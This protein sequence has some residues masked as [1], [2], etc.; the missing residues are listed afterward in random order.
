MNKKFLNNLKFAFIAQSVSILF[1]LIMYLI[2]PKIIGVINYSYWQLFLFYTNY[3]GFFHLGLVDGI[4][5][6]LGGREYKELNYKRIGSQFKIMFFFHMLIAIVCAIAFCC[7]DLEEERVFVILCTILYIVIY[8]IEN[9]LGFVLQ[10]VN[11][12]KKYSIAVIIEKIVCLIGT[13]LLLINR[14]E[15]FKWYVSLYV[16]SKFF[17]IIYLIISSKEI[18]FCEF[19]NLKKVLKEMRKNISI[20]SVLMFSGIASSLII[21]CGR[22]IIDGIWGIEKFGKVSF[23]ISMINMVLLFIRQVSMVLFPALR[24]IEENE[25]KRIYNFSK[26]ILYIMLPMIFIAYIP[27]KEILELW[28]PQYAESLQILAITLPICIF[29]AK[30]QILGN[31]YFKVL[32]KENILLKVN[33][34]VMIIS[35]ALSLFMGMVWNSMIAIVIVM[36]FCIALRSIISEIYLDRY[37]RNNIR[38]TLK[39]I[40]LETCITILFMYISYNYN[41]IIAF[42]IIVSVYVIY[43]IINYKDTGRLIKAVKEKNIRE[44]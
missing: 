32:R 11:L 42:I 24:E 18:V 6:K 9:F 41:N 40:L 2:L 1:S 7:S 38:E 14:I 22:M 15:S 29:D 4:Y 20:G 19:E 12:T 35:F 28:L 33:V 36:V 30:M 27:G 25:R 5:L 17:N 44:Y 26:S 8:C 39:S 10:A 3:S 13:G 31:T 21:G 37:Y 43:L 16:F 34:G 23:S